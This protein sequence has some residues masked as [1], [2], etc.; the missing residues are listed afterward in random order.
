MNLTEVTATSVLSAPSGYIGAYDYTLTPYLGCAFGCTYC[1]VPTMFY[2]RKLAPTWGQALAVK[3]NAPDLLLR[4]ARAGKLPGARIYCSPNTDPYVPQ[5][6]TYRITWRLL[7]VF[8]DYPP[9]LLVIQ[10]RSPR[11]LDDLD[12]LTRLGSRLVVALS[13][14]TNR[15]EMRRLFEPRCAPIQARVDALARLHQAGI[16]TQASL[17][18][19]LPCDAVE[20]AELVDAH[21][22]WVV[23]QTLKMRGPGAKT[24][25]PALALLRERRLEGWLQG[26]PRVAEAMAALRTAFGPRYHE[27]QEGFSLGWVAGGPSTTTS[28]P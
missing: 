27:G 10:T 3:V 18:P 28:T 25:K 8:C 16:Q 24:W 26:E 7:E 23:V 14:T 21:S 9:R 12:L 5:E 1:Y 4:E 6:R 22:D 15:E 13:I 19:L 11:V 20:L 17:A 2:Y